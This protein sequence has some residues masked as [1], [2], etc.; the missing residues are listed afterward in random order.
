[1]LALEEKL[2]RQKLKITPQR[3]E[4][5]KALNRVPDHPC[6]EVI[7]QAV[8]KRCPSVSL[9]TVYKTLDT[10]VAIGEI[11][12]ALVSEGK[13]RYDTRTDSH[14]HFLCKQCGYIEDINVSLDCVDT[15]LPHHLS[16]PHQI[17]R[18]EVVFRG[19]CHDCLNGEVK[20]KMPC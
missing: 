3:L 15:C 10:L 19:L 1:M 5:L 18:S 16:Q 7:Y 9:A 8:K 12:V 13:T 2:K 14:H 20:V 17:E 6:A 4:I 11:N